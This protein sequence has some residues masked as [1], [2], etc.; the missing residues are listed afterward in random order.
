MDDQARRDP[1]LGGTVPSARDAAATPSLKTSDERDT[2]ISGP[3]TRR[4]T[5]AEADAALPIQVGSVIN[6]K[7]RIDG[8]LGEGGVGVVFMAHHL[9]LDERVA[10]KFLKAESLRDSGIVARFAREAKAALAIKSEHVARIMDVGTMQDTGAPFIVMEY[11]EGSDVNSALKARGTFSVPDVAEYVLHACEALA[12]AH[13]KGIVHRDIKPENLFLTSTR[14]SMNVVKVLDF[15]VSKAALTGS[16]FR[17]EIPLVETSQ[18]MGTP[19]YMSPEQVRASSNVDARSDIWSLG[20]VIYEML[21]GQAAFDAKS[22][23]E[24]CAAILERDIPPVRDIRPDVPEG[25]AL[26]IQRCVQRDPAAR[27]QNVGALANAL[28]P[29]APKRARIYA[30]RA[31]AALREAGMAD[32]ELTVHSTIPPPT[33]EALEVAA[34]ITQRVR[35]GSSPVIVADAAPASTLAPHT[36]GRLVTL[37]ALVAVVAVAISVVAVF[38]ALH[39]SPADT[40]AIAPPAVAPV[41]AAPPPTLPPTSVAASAGAATPDPPP[42]PSAAQAA[43]N[44]TAVAASPPAAPATPPTRASSR[45]RAPESDKPAASAPAAAAAKPSPSKSPLG[46]E[47]P[48][49]G[50]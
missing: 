47:G 36:S 8:V 28:L 12:I 50:Y 45:A 29:F 11:L 25:M 21:T 16:M 4:A 5:G 20:L 2:K 24:L 34:N 6:G 43:A 48:D 3:R 33:D 9:E 13:S 19:L 27:Y 18:L 42:Q 32:P 38:L 26:A 39:R 49:L 7:Y 41:A 23:N 40:A 44:A 15:G 10:I 46:D 1:S 37:F 17:G 14:H 30:E 35:A 31:V 22:L